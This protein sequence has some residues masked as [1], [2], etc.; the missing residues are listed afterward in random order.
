MFS[1]FD[2]LVN[3]PLFVIGQ[4]RSG[5]TVLQNALISHP[6]IT[7]TSYE[8]P[9]ISKLGGFVYDFALSE[10]KHYNLESISLS[11][12]NLRAELKQIIIKSVFGEKY[13]RWFLYYT[14]KNG[15]LKFPNLWIAKTFPCLTSF[16]GLKYLFPKAKFIYI[17]RI[18]Y[19]QI[20]SSMKYPGKRGKKFEVYCKDWTK[21]LIIIIMCLITLIAML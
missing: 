7:G 20:N 4:G 15:T 19:D 2:N 21:A 5:T 3:K 16:L 1:F 6:L 10:F 18:G 12:E 17:Y 13:L 14:F 8:S 11:D 9:I